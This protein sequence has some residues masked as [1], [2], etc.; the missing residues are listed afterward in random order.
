M[1]KGIQ[2]PFPHF[3]NAG[4]RFEDQTER[5]AWS[6]GWITKGFKALEEVEILI[7]TLAST[8]SLA[9]CI[10]YSRFSPLHRAH[11]VLETAS[12]WQTAASCHKY[13]I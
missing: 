8:A 7:F 1:S 9:T 4:K 2:S 10:S 3:Q 12:A 5:E 13:D 11:A 6:K